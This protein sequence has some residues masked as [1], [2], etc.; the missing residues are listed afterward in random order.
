MVET[1]GSGEK[2]AMDDEKTVRKGKMFSRRK[3]DALT[4]QGNLIFG[5]SVCIQVAHRIQVNEKFND[6]NQ[7]IKALRFIVKNI[8]WWLLMRNFI[9]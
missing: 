4:I 3:T 6:V 1:Y 7:R 9:E 2:M 8:S 5:S